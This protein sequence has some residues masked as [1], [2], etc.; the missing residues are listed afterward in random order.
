MPMMMRIIVA[1]YVTQA[2][3]GFAVGLVLPWFW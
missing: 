1:I 2:T 3:V